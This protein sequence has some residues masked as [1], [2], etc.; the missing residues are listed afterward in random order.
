[1]ALNLDYGCDD[2]QSWLSNQLQHL[3]GFWPKILKSWEV[4]VQ[5]LR[6]TVVHNHQCTW[7]RFE[8]AWNNRK[9]VQNSSLFDWK[10]YSDNKV[11]PEDLGLIK[12]QSRQ[13]NYYEHERLIREGYWLKDR[14]FWKTDGVASCRVVLVMPPCSWT[15]NHQHD[16][17]IV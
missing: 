1:M 11:I 14:H 12:V 17:Y 4:E 10:H 6:H 7:R 5:L 2:G 13:N 3:L 9:M 15:I 8:N 16:M